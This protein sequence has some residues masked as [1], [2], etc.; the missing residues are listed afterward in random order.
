MSIYI[1][2][3][4]MNSRRVLLPESLNDYKNSKDISTF[5]HYSAFLYMAFFITLG[6]GKDFEHFKHGL[7]SNLKM[8]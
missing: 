1:Y 8:N 5:S 6:C 4:S 3:G 7:Y 2:K